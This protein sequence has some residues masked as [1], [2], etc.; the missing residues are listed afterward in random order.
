MISSLIGIKAFAC[1]LSHFSE[2]G[3]RH[4][5]TAGECGIMWNNVE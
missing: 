4:S 2:D 3:E 1:N 5:K